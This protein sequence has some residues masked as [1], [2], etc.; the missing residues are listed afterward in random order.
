MASRVERST[1]A[2][3]CHIPATCAT[4]RPH[5]GAPRDQHS[6]ARPRTTA[7]A[8][9]A[10]RRDGAADARSPALG[11]GSSST[12]TGS[13]G[14][15]RAAGCRRSP[16][17][18]RPRCATT[19]CP[20][21]PAARGAST[22]SAAVG[23]SRRSLARRAAGPGGQ[24]VWW[25]SGAARQGVSARGHGSVGSARGLSWTTIQGPG[26]GDRA[27]A[28][29]SRRAAGA[30]S[31][32]SGR[33]ALE[34]SLGAPPWVRW[35]DEFAGIWHVA[36]I[37]LHSTLLATAC[38]LGLLAAPALAPGRP[39][40]GEPGRP[41]QLPPVALLAAASGAAEGPAEAAGTAVDAGRLLRRGARAPAVPACAAER[42]GA[43]DGRRQG[44]RGGLTAGAFDAF[45]QGGRPPRPRSTGPPTTACT[46][47]HDVRAAARTSR[48]RRS[49]PSSTSTTRDGS[50]LLDR[51]GGRRLVLDV[52]RRQGRTGQQSAM[53]STRVDG[54]PSLL[55]P[56]TGG[57]P[58]RHH[59]GHVP[60]RHVPT[61]S[62]GSRARAAR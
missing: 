46:G 11:A 12:T 20:P 1:I 19:G 40:A 51:P 38:A 42:G 21:A 27:S 29:P 22:T 7:A 45:G 57:Q 56:A 24:P 28:A 62:T 23:A 53:S 18:R 47:G 2:A 16:A 39:Q 25:R 15:D 36:A 41:G 58:A 10:A 61:A 43:D 5:G 35:W 49:T 13:G 17:G 30:A 34:R 48:R 4:I 8:A 52:L 44:R 32:S 14:S 59:A 33:A 54:P 55:R 31:G 37:V 9:L 60:E 50:R 6:G 3:T 26:A